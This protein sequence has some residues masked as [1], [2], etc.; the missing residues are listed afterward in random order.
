MRALRRILPAA[1]A[2]ALMG[3]GVGFPLPTENRVAVPLP[4]DG[5]YQMKQTWKGMSGIRDVLLTQESGSHARLTRPDVFG[6]VFHP[7][8]VRVALRV[9]LLLDAAHPPCLIKQNRP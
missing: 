9:L 8:W 7:S 6:R 3:C 5:S 2:L 1:L 4:G